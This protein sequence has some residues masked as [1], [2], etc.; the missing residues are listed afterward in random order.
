MA[1]RLA[2]WMSVL[3]VL[4]SCGESIGSVESVEPGERIEAEAAP[5]NVEDSTSSTP[6]SPP[7]EPTPTPTPPPTNT[8]HVPNFGA[9]AV[10]LYATDYTSR[11]ERSSA[12]GLWYLQSPGN[13]QSWSTSYLSLVT[14]PWNTS[15][16]AVLAT[17]H[18]GDNWNG[19]GY[20]RSELS[21]TKSAVR[22]QG[23]QHYFISLGFQFPSSA[24]SYIN[25]NSSEMLGVFQLHHPESTGTP[26]FAF[27]LTGNTLK[28]RCV[29]GSASSPQRMKDYALFPAGGVPTNRLVSI[30]MEYLPHTS[31]GLLKVYVDGELK[32]S[33]TGGCAYTNSGDAGYIKQ[34]LYDYWRTVPNT[35]SVYLE[36]FVLRRK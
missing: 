34:G 19:Q 24:A 13:A 8:A 29:G 20:P 26:P 35:L 25:N 2:V 14:A 5:E 15:K 28:V 7:P 17:I 32:V 27:Y 31:S 36:D 30:D 21:A 12:G 4:T 3:L 11:D 16:R 10:L 9:G 23:G 1:S 22:I 6:S 33:H 18:R